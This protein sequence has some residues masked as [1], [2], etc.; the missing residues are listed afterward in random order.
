[1]AR[2][3]REA[4]GRD[5]RVEHEDPFV[6]LIEP[7]ADDT[8]VRDRVVLGDADFVE[9]E[10][11]GTVPMISKVVNGCGER[12]L[13]TRSQVEQPD[14]GHDREARLHEH[15]CELRRNL[16]ISVGWRGVTQPSTYGTIARTVS[17][18]SELGMGYRE[19]GS[20]SHVHLGRRA[21]D[22]L[23]TSVKS[24]GMTS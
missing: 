6:R 14:L 15:H 13:P 5:G 18:A 21:L 17:E 7:V 24:P 4:R 19:Y 3:L 1:M 10:P 23:P 9:V 20:A 2:P 16:V 8:R 22:A 11:S 12:S